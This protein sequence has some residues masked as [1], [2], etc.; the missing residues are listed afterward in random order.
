M[1][2]RKL[3]LRAIVGALC[4]TAAVAIVVLLTGSFEH[5]EW[6][7]LATTSAVSAFGL[8]AVP[9][10]ML[11]ER[12]TAVVL[13]RTSAALTASAFVLTLVVVWDS[14]SSLLGRTWGVVLTLALAAAQAATVEARR[15]DNDSQAVR[16]L[17]VGSTLTGAVLAALGVFGILTE[18]HGT[19]YY[20]VIGAIAIL[21]VLLLA[22]TA[23]L[24]RGTGPVS[25]T[26]RIRVD[27]ELI[28]APGR[29]FASAVSAA[30]RSAERA[31]KAV[32]RIERV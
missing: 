32:R 29:D 17:T 20:R 19:T 8:L 23:I 30:I 24:R 6:R 25:Q 16:R 26:H 2:A 13:A 11:L 9:A 21:D 14:G 28:E 7:I 3:L 22:L 31:G 12:G 15:R 10:G 1:Q 18:I 27:G 4:V 5:T